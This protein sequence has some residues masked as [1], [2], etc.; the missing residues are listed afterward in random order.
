MQPGP[1]TFDTGYDWVKK[2]TGASFGTSRRD[3]HISK[4][5]S[6]IPGPGNYELQNY[7]PKSGPGFTMGTGASAGGT[8]A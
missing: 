4:S 5:V 2:K 6:M 1:G 7:R 8:K 3:G